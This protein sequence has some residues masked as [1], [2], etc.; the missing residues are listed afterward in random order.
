M[1]Q[2]QAKRRRLD[3]AEDT[4]KS[5]VAYFL[6]REILWG[7]MS[8]AGAKKIADLT[9]KDVA[10]A[11]LEGPEFA[12]PELDTLASLPHTNTYQTL[13]DKLSPPALPSFDFDLPMKFNNAIGF[14]RQCAMWP[15]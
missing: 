1:W 15:H 7:S 4:A 13:L 11:H 3:E 10:R 14:W 6:V 9:R 5:E 8:L 2:R 12:F